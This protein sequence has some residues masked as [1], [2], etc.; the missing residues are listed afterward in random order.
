MKTTAIYLAENGQFGYR[1]NTF[2][3]E[4]GDR[5]K[6]PNGNQKCEIIKIVET[7]QSNLQYLTELI[8]TVDK[9][10]F[11]T[12]TWKSEEAK[13]SFIERMLAIM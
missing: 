3:W 7:T 2:N 13:E 10:T 5:I 9:Y 11:G 1:S 8:N 6:T 4:V 12:K